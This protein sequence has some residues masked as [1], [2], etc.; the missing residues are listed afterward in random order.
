MKSYQLH[1]AE[2]RRAIF[3]DLPAPIWLEKELL[4]V[5]VVADPSL[6]LQVLRNP[7]AVVSTLPELVRII[8]RTNGVSLPN[9][10]YAC[11][12]LPVLVDESAH[13]AVRK[14]FA[15]FLAARLGELEP[16]LPA[17]SKSCLAPLAPLTRPGY[18]DIVSGVVDPFIEQ[19][20]SILLQCRLPPEV[21]SLGLGNILS[22]NTNLTRLKSLDARIG[23][24]LSFLRGASA[25]EEEVGW[26]FTCL[27]FG[28]DTLAMMLTEGIVSAFRDGEDAAAGARLPQ[29]PVETGVPVTFR[30]ARSS[31]D[32]SG[33]SIQAGDLL[34]LQLQAFGYSM[35]ADDRRFI[36]GAGLHSCIGKQMSLRVWEHFRREFDQLDLKA[37][38]V[39]Y[40]LS[41][42]HFIILHKS[43]QLEVL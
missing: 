12:V 6:L 17:L 35:N 26:K 30:R 1:S 36:F 22:F 40:E 31:F 20:F 38:I 24:I 14:G 41:P 19:V 34:R 39:R 27:V 5:W 33:C 2:N 37:R 15:T 8:E 21:L 3:A 16:H 4:R 9:V 10:A 43:V 29:F 7:L 42:S 13:P 23:K 18:V 11:S 25:S 28:V 32:L